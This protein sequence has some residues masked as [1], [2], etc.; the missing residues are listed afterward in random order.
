[1]APMWWVGVGALERA[2]NRVAFADFGETGPIG[3]FGGLAARLGRQN[4]IERGAPNAGR[5]G[6]VGTGGHEH[7]AA[8]AHVTGN[9]VEVNQRQHT[10]AGIAVKDNELEF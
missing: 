8:L 7:G 9:V 1:M 3:L 6:V 2:G 4:G 5:A 10:L